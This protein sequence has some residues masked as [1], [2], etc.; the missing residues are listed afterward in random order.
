MGQKEVFS[1]LSFSPA[2]KL[3]F[4]D[5]QPK[6]LKFPAFSEALHFNHGFPFMNEGKNSKIYL[7]KKKIFI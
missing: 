2:E 6:K 7:L 4:P 1:L 5:L 3:L